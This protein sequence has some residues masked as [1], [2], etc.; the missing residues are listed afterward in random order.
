MTRFIEISLTLCAAIL[1]L[2][3]VLVGIL[4]FLVIMIVGVIEQDRLLG[5]KRL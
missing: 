1:A 4:V 2:P 5:G 3:F